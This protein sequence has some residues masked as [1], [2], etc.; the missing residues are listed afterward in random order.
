MNRNPYLGI[1]PKQFTDVMEQQ[2]LEYGNV[3]SANLK[4]NWWKMAFTLNQHLQNAGTNNKMMVYRYPMPTGGGKSTGL[5][6]YLALLGALAQTRDRC[7]GAIVTTQYTAECDRI[8]SEINQIGREYG[9]KEDMAVALHS[10]VNR[11]GLQLH[12]WPFVIT[13]QAGM[14]RALVEEGNN[15]LKRGFKVLPWLMQYENGSQVWEDLIHEMVT[16]PRNCLQALESLGLDGKL[17]RQRSMVI[18]DEMLTPLKPHYLTEDGIKALLKSIPRELAAKHP[19]AMDGIGHVL[20]MIA[21]NSAMNPTGRTRFTEADRGLTLWREQFPSIVPLYKELRDGFSPQRQKFPKG[22]PLSYSDTMDMLT[23]IYNIKE[24]GGTVAIKSNGAIQSMF[25]V[26]WLM[27]RL[28]MGFV[29]LDA[30]A[31]ESKLLDACEAHTTVRLKPC[32]DYQNLTLELDTS[33]GGTGRGKLAGNW[34][35][36]EDRERILNTTIDNI[37]NSLKTI[38]PKQY[39][40]VGLISFKPIIEALNKKRLSLP[41]MLITGWHGNVIGK[42]DWSDVNMLYIVGLNH[43]E[44]TYGDEMMLGITDHIEEMKELSSWTPNVNIPEFKWSAPE[45]AAHDLLRDLIQVISRG[46]NRRTV[47]RSGNC[48]ESTVRITV[49]SG[50]IKDFLIKGLA[51]HF[52][53]VKIDTESWRLRPNTYTMV[54]A[55]AEYLN[56]KKLMAKAKELGKFNYDTALHWFNL[57]GW[58]DVSLQQL[59]RIMDLKKPWPTK[60]KSAF[61]DSPKYQ[62][63]MKELGI[64]YSDTVRSLKHPKGVCGLMKA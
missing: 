34:K 42:N 3:A 23:A 29:C 24:C 9:M 53:D 22:S 49:G 32:R 40:K 35:P 58:E 13:T 19:D 6:R 17:K 44:P 38:D 28:K 39:P 62:Q 7:P 47:D 4:H 50:A 33:D 61:R 48:C 2:W 25:K 57:S 56:E 36:E 15:D 8:A 26:D 21:V 11:K 59:C 51:N 31:K 46:S 18:F 55:E 5:P 1:D 60:F 45:I 52:R 41:F 37:V 30:T 64:K 14:T 54:D 63:L 20:S 43:M 16:G 12:S 10:G 27:D